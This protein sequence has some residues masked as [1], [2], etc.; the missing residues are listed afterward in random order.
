MN[1]NESI[2]NYI[3][4]NWSQND[5]AMAWQVVCET[6]N[7]EPFYLMAEFDEM[8]C[9]MSP[10]EIVSMVENNEF[11]SNDEYFSFSPNG[12]IFSFSDIVTNPNFDSDEIIRY[13]ENYGLKDLPNIDESVLRDDFIG[14]CFPDY[15]YS[16]VNDAIDNVLETE[17]FSFID[18]DWDWIATI[19]EEY[20]WGEM[21]D[22]KE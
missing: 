22:N 20:L 11:N 4:E 2:K 3:F 12:N 17:T 13:I 5:M 6:N 21:S 9:N 18:D 1:K 16:D 15:D 7:Y 8:F 10:L 19:V 14:D